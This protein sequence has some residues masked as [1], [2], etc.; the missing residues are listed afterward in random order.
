VEDALGA[1]VV[2]AASQA[3][4][5]SPG[6]AA[7]VRLAN[8]SRAFVKAVCSTSNADSPDIHRREARIAAALPPNAPVPAFR[9]SYDDGEWVVLVFDDV[10]GSLPALP[11]QPVQLT[12]VLLALF[13]MARTLTPSPVAVEPAGEWLMRIFGCWAAFAADEAAAAQ[14][15]PEWRDR[16]DE[17]VELEAAIPAAVEGDT[18]LH[19]DTRADNILLTASQVFVVDWPWAAI[20]APWV[21][22]AAF[23]P[24]VAM[25]G[26]PAPDEIWAEHPLSHRVDGERVDAFLAGLAGMFTYQALQPAPPGLPTLR[27]FQRAQGDQTRGWLARRRAWPFL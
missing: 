24:S 8:G 5:F 18:L 13:E 7:R 16:L 23:L 15:A 12:R 9:G 22:L 10:D 21:D 27:P 25:Q 20:G 11:W 4:G 17:L 1:R 26:G 3:G 2:H 14:L 6:V 19:L